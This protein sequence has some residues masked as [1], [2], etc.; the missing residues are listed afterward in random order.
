MSVL[1]P[2]IANLRDQFFGALPFV[3]A[4][5]RNLCLNVIR[6]AF[7]DTTGEQN[8]VQVMLHL[9]TRSGPTVVE[10]SVSIVRGKSELRAILM[11]REVDSSLVSLLHDECSVTGGAV[12]LSESNDDDHSRPIS[13]DEC[14]TNL[15]VA[16]TS[17]STNP[18]MHHNDD[19]E[20]VSTMS[21]LTIAS[22]GS[23]GS[24]ARGIN[25]MLGF[26]SNTMG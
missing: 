25:S 12:P 21:S 5:A 8:R 10:M 11:G 9:C 16:M 13:E 7:G 14:D 19:D 26:T 4:R 22:S 18:Q 6:R 24:A 1:I 23:V 17:S 20:K 3:H 15:T 2:L